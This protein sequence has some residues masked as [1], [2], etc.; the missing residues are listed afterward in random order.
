MAG[1]HAGAL[2]RVLRALASVGIFSEDDAGRFHN[3]PLAEP[4]R[5][6]IPGSLRAFVVMQGEPES[7]QPWG[8]LLYSVRTGEPAF[9]H[10]FGKPQ[11]QYLAENPAPARVFDEAMAS[12]SAA[13]IE[14]FLRRYDFSGAA[15]VT[16]VGGGNGAFLGAILEKHPHL[17]GLLFE[18]PHVIERAR[19]AWENSPQGARF[20]FEGG[21]FFRAVPAGGEIYVLKKIIHDWDDGRALKILQ[22][23]RRAMPDNGRLLLIELVVPPG[24][25]PSFSKL[26]DLLML[27]WPGG[28]ERTEDEYRKIL[29]SAGLRTSRV[30]PT[31]SPVSIIEATA[32]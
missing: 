25:A 18:M 8:Q 11:F 22:N 31:Q 6:A 27:I 16:D 9:D 24:N 28:R 3:T 26:L 13:E 23:C 1:A 4:L 19:L 32:I 29:L 2:Y 10:V 12:R 21:D 5:T 15:R 30:I 17:R 20:E 7:W 14:A